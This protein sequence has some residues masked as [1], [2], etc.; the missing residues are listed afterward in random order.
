MN[1]WNS[2]T[3]QLQQNTTTSRNL[4][5]FT[6]INDTRPVESQRTW[7]FHLTTENAFEIRGES[8]ICYISNWWINDFKW[9]RHKQS[10]LRF[11]YDILVTKNWIVQVCSEP[12]SFSEHRVDIYFSRVFCGR[13]I[14]LK[15]QLQCRTIL[16]TLAQLFCL[17]TEK[18]ALIEKAFQRVLS[19]SFLH[20]FWC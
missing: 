10:P 7:T 6:M 8:C 15:S 16:V 9:S 14:N 12:L 5:I 1:Q 17:S 18:N 19:F 11:D 13:R 3:Q 4:A 20:W 2:R